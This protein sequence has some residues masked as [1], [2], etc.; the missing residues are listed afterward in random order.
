MGT[1]Q[2]PTLAPGALAHDFDMLVHEDKVHRL[3]YTDPAI[4][5]LE[6]RR[7]FGA[8]AAPIGA[9]PSAAKPGARPRPSSAPITAGPFTI[10][11]S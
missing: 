2:K 9:R 1:Q 4:F 5:A 6:M 7:I 11:G 3:L 8:T 10:P